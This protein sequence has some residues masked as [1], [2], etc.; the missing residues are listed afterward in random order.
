MSLETA[1]SSCSG[2]NGLTT[3][4]RGREQQA[5]EQPGARSSGGNP[6][7][8]PGQ[9]GLRPEGWADPCGPG[10]WLEHDFS[11]PEYNLN[12]RGWTGPLR[13]CPPILQHSTAKMLK[14]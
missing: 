13:G 4:A 10:K 14:S 11:M 7:A 9:S 6:G 1:W 8:G 5:P 3:Q 12:V 2:L